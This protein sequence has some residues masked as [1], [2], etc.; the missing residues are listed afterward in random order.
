MYLNQLNPSEKCKSGFVECD[1]MSRWQTLFSWCNACLLFTP[2]LLVLNGL[3]KGKR[4]ERGAKSLFPSDGWDNFFFISFWWFGDGRSTFFLAALDKHRHSG[5]FYYYYILFC[6]CWRA[7]RRAGPWISVSV[8]KTVWL[9]RAARGEQS[10]ARRNLSSSWVV[11]MGKLS[12]VSIA[13][14][15]WLR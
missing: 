3:W 10:W 7:K 2:T 9:G 12:C 5:Y 4:Q 6:C 13:P 15:R 11:L 14:C 8:S 1:L